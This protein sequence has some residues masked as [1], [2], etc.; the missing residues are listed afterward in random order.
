M[1]IYKVIN[2]MEQDY[3]CEELPENQEYCVDVILQDRS[4]NKEIT[5]AVPDAELYEKH[6]D[7]DSLIYYNGKNIISAE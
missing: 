1:K 6:I 4:T 7:V 5:I 2:I 3:G